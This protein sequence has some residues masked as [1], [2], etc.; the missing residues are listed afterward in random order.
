LNWQAHEQ[1]TPLQ[2]ITHKAARMFHELVGQAAAQGSL[3]TQATVVNFNTPRI[4]V[5]LQRTCGFRIR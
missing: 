4:R 1:N 5:W 3:R 2:G